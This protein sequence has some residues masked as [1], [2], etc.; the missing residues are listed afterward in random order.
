MSKIV[1]RIFNT[2]L[3]ADDSSA[4]EELGG[5]RFDGGKIYKYVQFQ[6]S[7]SAAE[8]APVIYDGTSSYKVTVDQDAG[9]GTGSVA[10][11][12]LTNNTEGYYGWIQL[13]GPAVV[14]ITDYISTGRALIVSGTDL[15]WSAAD[16]TSAAV[17]V[18]L[19]GACA[20]Q[21][22]ATDA[23]STITAMI[24]CL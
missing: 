2:V 11:V 21:D 24:K 15:F 9:A 3:T 23:N 4:Q 17:D 16:L 10:G 5:F 6:D 1:D 14:K 22:S 18:V 8:G 20:L 13:H 12:A 7:I 19:R